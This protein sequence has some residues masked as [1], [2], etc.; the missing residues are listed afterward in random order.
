MNPS[1]LC[2]LQFWKSLDTCIVPPAI[3]VRPADLGEHVPVLLAWLLQL[4]ALLEAG[5][6]LRSLGQVILDL[7]ASCRNTAKFNTML[8]AQ[9]LLCMQFS[10]TNI[11]VYPYMSEALDSTAWSLLWPASAT[12]CGE[13]DVAP[14]GPEEIFVEG[15]APAVASIDDIPRYQP[16]AQIKKRTYRSA[17]NR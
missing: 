9:M 3:A 17:L 2:T 1:V 6:T 13:K 10:T 14:S 8:L 7:T 5:Q 12:S 11:A 4:Q 16:S 15:P